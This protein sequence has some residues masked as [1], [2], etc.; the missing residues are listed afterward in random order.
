MCFI[1]L[2]SAP[3]QWK[4][5]EVK[6]F[7]NTL[8]HIKN[9]GSVCMCVCVC[10]GGGGRGDREEEGKRRLIRKNE[11]VNMMGKESADG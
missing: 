3:F 5:I 6:M 11:E 1:P 4:I 7:L 2:G 8:L 9:R 10:V